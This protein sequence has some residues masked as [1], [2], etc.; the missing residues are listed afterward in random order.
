MKMLAVPLRSKF[1][2]HTL[3]VRF[4]RGD[5]HLRLLQQLHGLFVHAQHR[6]LRVIRFRISFEHVLHVGHELGVLVGRNH[7][8]LDL[9][10]GHA[11]FF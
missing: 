10:L 3:R 4:R 6:M 7:P 1:G 11:V 5:R 2:T 9:A 8:I